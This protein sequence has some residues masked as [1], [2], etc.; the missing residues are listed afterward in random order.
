[1]RYDGHNGQIT[2]EEST[3]GVQR[4]GLAARAAFGSDTPTWVVPLNGVASVEFEDATMLRNG[5]LRILVPGSTPGMVS[6]SNA[7][8]SGDTVLFT[9]KQAP[10]FA[11]VRDWLIT[12]AHANHARAA[13]DGWPVVPP[14]PL[15]R[16]KAVAVEKGGASDRAPSAAVGS[17]DTAVGDA[18]SRSSWRPS[19][20]TPEP[21]ILLR[22]RGWSAQQVA[23]ESHYEKQLRKLAGRGTGERDIVAT[24]QHDPG[25]RYD[26]NAV[27][28]LIDGE[29]VGFL[30][31]EDAP[32]YG[33]LLAEVARRGGVAVAAG[34]LWWSLDADW[35]NASVTLDVHEPALALF[36]ND[37]G[38]QTPRIILPAGS[39]YQVTGESEHLAHL[40]GVLSRAYV[41]GK[42]AAYATLGVATVS[43]SRTSTEVVSVS[44]D[45][46]LAGTL[47]KQT[48]AKLLPLVAPMAARGIP[49]WCE[50]TLTGN[51]LAVEATVSV[52]PVEQLPSDLVAE[53]TRLSA[54]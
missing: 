5:W 43:T 21:A 28:V 47:S 20:S 26:K 7:A 27:K 49:V 2:V 4:E 38:P 44:V 33:P 51:A 1:M 19:R 54:G 11:Q 29:H 42:A 3:L 9:R 18:S 17:E 24:L 23:G 35:F 30:P 10:L 6:K 22:G 15:G 36:I 31:K 40:A 34:R 12:L 16:A 46:G 14:P 25:N 53:V 50:A 32:A 41:P 52:T 13:K 37:I 48:S 45:G 8:G 39:N